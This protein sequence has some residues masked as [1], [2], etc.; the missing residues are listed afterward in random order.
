MPTLA[1]QSSRSS[2]TTLPVTTPT[3]SLA[4][5]VSM[6]VCSIFLFLLFLIAAIAQENGFHEFSSP[7]I[8]QENG[9]QNA[10]LNFNVTA[11][12]FN[13]NIGNFYNAMHIT[14]SY[15]DQS[16]GATSL[17]FPFY[18]GPQNTTILASCLSGVTLTV[19]NQRWQEFLADRS[20]GRVIFM[21]DVTS[22][23]RF[24]ISW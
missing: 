12:N 3:W 22:R 17:L 18:Q 16:V 20:Q 14:I 5:R 19:N 11:C 2:D 6:L 15:D 10:Q 8:A 9:F 21:L 23:I 7:A 24:K 13:R 1:R 4:T